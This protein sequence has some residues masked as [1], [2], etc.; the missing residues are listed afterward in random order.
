MNQLTIGQLINAAPAVAKFESKVAQELI[1]AMTKSIEYLLEENAELRK[2]L[3][4]TLSRT[5]LIN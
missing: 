1:E 3:N 5:I 4:G 2:N